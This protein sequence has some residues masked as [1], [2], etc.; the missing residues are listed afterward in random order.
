[1]EKEL[2]AEKEV[3]EI[4][5]LGWL[6][7]ALSKAISRKLLVFS[8]T[9]GLLCAGKIGPDEYIFVACIYIGVQGA[10]DFFK[11]RK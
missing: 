10:I 6:D 9:T 4:E 8:I 5:K 3:K 7:N 2:A 11:L 1:M